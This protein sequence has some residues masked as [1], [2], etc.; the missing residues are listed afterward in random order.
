MIKHQLVMSLDTGSLAS[1]LLKLAIEPKL[2]GSKIE[3]R[4]SKANRPERAHS[5]NWHVIER[6]ATKYG[7][8]T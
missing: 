4:P 3:L 1:A 7:G 8:L 5:K 2:K 6:P